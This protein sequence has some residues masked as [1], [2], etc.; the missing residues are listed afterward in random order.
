VSLVT[1]LQADP[2]QRLRDLADDQPVALHPE[3]DLIDV[4]TK[5]ADFNLITL[6]IVDHDHR[7]IGLVT[8]DD[9][10]ETTIPHNW[11]RRGPSAHAIRRPVPVVDN[12]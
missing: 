3:A 1:V 5:M 7:L 11:R 10:L 2:A 9:V 6:P 12:N 4:T 8:V